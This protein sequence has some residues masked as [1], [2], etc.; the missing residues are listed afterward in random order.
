MTRAFADPRFIAGLAVLSGIAALS[1]A[2]VAVRVALAAPLALVLPG[3]ALSLA[4]LP[5]SESWLGR[6]PVSVATSVVLSGITGLALAATPIGLTRFVWAPLL[7]GVTI[8]GAAIAYSRSPEHELSRI[9]LGMPGRPVLALVAAAALVMVAV[10]LARTPLSA[11]HI[12]GYSALWLLPTNAESDSIRIGVTNSEFTDT[13]YRVVLYSE[14]RAIFQRPLK[15]SAGERWSAVIDVSSI[16]TEHR[17]F[18]ARLIKT[19][20]PSPPYREAT[21]VLPGSTVPPVTD[22][23]LVPGQVDSGTMRVLV[24]SAEPRTKRFRL[25]LRAGRDV[26]KVIHPRLQPG[27]TWSRTIDFASVPPGQ[28]VFE[29]RLYHAGAGAPLR[30]ATLAPTAG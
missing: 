10:T 24:T 29:A 20:D 23:W 22:V 18:D 3:W 1:P 6:L 13:S 17:S 30:Q 16:P 27:E 4:F 28:R 11:G 14:G 7:A 26:Y 9:R 12:R 21:L 25:E 15:L 8:L 2:P 19:G 5:D